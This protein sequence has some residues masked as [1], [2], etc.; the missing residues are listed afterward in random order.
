MNEI[1]KIPTF[2]ELLKSSETREEQNA[3]NFL[4]NQNPP[5]K[6]VEI[7]PVYKNKYLSIEKIEFLLTKI[8]VEWKVEIKDVKML[9]NSVICTVRLHFKNPLTNDWQY[10]DGVGAS[11]LQ[12]NSG[13]GAIDFNQLKSNSVMLAAPIAE[14][15]A[16]KDAAEK[17]GRIFGKDLNRKN[18]QN[19]E[20]L[21]KNQPLKP[22]IKNE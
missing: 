2:D 18:L 11:G 3:L 6:W 10:H 21:L 17:I 12:V 4:L 1:K 22:T 5:E 8:F 7:H 16:I 20:N 19:Y 15:F 13:A 9:A 14:S